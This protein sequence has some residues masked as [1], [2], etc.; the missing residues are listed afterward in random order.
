MQRVREAVSPH[1]IKL[2]APARPRPKRRP[3]LVRSPS[4]KPLARRRKVLVLQVT[5][6][7]PRPFKLQQVLS[8]AAFPLVCDIVNCISELLESLKV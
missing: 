7:R 8:S 1:P 3:V 4:L 2:V 5:Q 6:A